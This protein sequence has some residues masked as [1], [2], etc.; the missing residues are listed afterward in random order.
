MQTLRFVIYKKLDN[1]EAWLFLS[2]QYD[3]TM[4]NKKTTPSGLYA[5][6]IDNAYQELV[7][8]ATERIRSGQLA[9][10]RA[11]NKEI[12]TL[13]ACLKF[14]SLG[15]NRPFFLHF[16]AFFGYVALLCS[17]KKSRTGEKIAQF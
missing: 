9:A 13:S 16:P 6:S 2:K 5:E 14:P 8:D 11:V 17:L 15:Q 1:R 10:L 7:A 12:I 4:T 3:I